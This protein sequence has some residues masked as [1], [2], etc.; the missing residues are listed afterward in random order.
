MLQM[1]VSSQQTTQN[2]QQTAQ[3]QL[4]KGYLDIK[5]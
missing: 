2:P 4:E 5:V 3:K 1:L